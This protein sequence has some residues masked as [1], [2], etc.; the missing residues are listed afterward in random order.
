[1]QDKYSYSS[2][3]IP[4][5][6]L[7]AAVAALYPYYRYYIDPDAVA[8]LSVARRYAAGDYARAV[9]GYWSPLSCWLTA[10]LIKWNIAEFRA[11]IIVNTFAAAG[12]LTAAHQLFARFINK[13]SALLLLT[14]TLAGVL[15]YAVFKQ[16]FADL[17]GCF[18][19]LTLLLILL[20]DGF[21]RKPALWVAGGFVIALAYYAKAYAF[22]F[23]LLS[24]VIV[25]AF[26]IAHKSAFGWERWLKINI[27]IIIVALIACF[28]WFWALYRHY[29]Q[30]MTGTAG[31]LNL[32]WY[33]VGHPH[34][35]QGIHILLPP[36]YPDAVY[37][38]EDPFLVNGV[39]PHF[40]NSIS[41]FLLQIVRVGY[42]LLKFLNSANELSCFFFPIYTLALIGI[43][44]KKWREQAGIKLIL[45][46]CCL[47]LFPVGY[48]LINFEARYLWYMLPGIMLLGMLIIQR[49]EVLLNRQ[50]ATILLIAFCCSFLTFPVWDMKTLFNE[51][52]DEYAMAADLKQHGIDGSFASN[53]AYGKEMQH[54]V[55]LAYFSGNSFYY[56]PEAPENNMELLQ[57]LRR[58]QVKYYFHFHMPFDN[59]VDFKDEQGHSFPVVYADSTHAG[60]TVF[61]LH[62]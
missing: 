9:N 30:W 55:R 52:K 34:F 45:V 12:F 57:E 38:W 24:A 33:L 49:L 36:A 22:P 60:V 5:L 16:S 51:G 18:F 20:R 48:L 39:A 46:N 19:L 28:P 44:F 41:L 40:W 61:L 56:M 47:V 31:S 29:G 4:L 8:C 35:K 2:L 11:A 25:T 7:L 43:L 26:I 58:Y 59:Q 10:L 37:Y 23:A 21:E 54:V 15:V 42:N 17:W 32:S 53:I 50:G 3:F 14:G 6:L 27:V 13:R 62:S 1:M